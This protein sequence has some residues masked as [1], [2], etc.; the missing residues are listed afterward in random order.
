VRL[1]PMP[2]TPQL[3]LN[4]LGETEESTMCDPRAFAER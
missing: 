1:P 3:S 2:L 4:N